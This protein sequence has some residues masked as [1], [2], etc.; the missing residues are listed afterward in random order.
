MLECSASRIPADDGVSTASILLVD[1]SAVLD[2]KFDVFP[3]IARNE[4]L[5]LEGLVGGV[6]R[7][8]V[9]SVLQ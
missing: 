7:V 3:L 1:V 4:C 2:Q 5:K 6:A 8:G 9:A